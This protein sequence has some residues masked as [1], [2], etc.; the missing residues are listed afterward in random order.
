MRQSVADASHERRTPL[1]AI[2]DYTQLMRMTDEDDGGLHP[3]GQKSH[4]LV[5][6]QSERM[7][8]LV[9]NM[10][11][12]ARLHEGQPL[13]LNEVDLAQLMMESVSAERVMAPSNNWRPELP[14][15]PVVVTGD[16]SQLRQVLMNLLSN[17]RKHTPA[18]TTFVSGVG[19]T[20]E[21]AA[22]VTVTDDGGGIP[23]SFVDHVFSRF[24][25][26]DAAWKGTRDGTGAAA[27]E[28]SQRSG[29]IRP[30]IHRGG[31]W[32]KGNGDIT[33]RAY[34]VRLTAPVAARLVARGRAATVSSVTKM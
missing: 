22:L 5:Q 2:R 10:L 26:A 33:T 25:R 24:A 17:A 19:R 28:G 20:A 30:G 29:V 27:A 3:R 12:L 8:A 34:R 32:R 13:K 9:E 31:P 23:A 14:D 6:S 7:A 21:G 4:A 1:T 15:G 18:G 11:L 16:A